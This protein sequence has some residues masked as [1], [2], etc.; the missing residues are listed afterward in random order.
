MD[1]VTGLRKVKNQRQQTIDRHGSGRLNAHSALA[2]VED[3]AK[4][5][6][7]VSGASAQAG[8]GWAVDPVTYCTPPV[9]PKNG[10]FRIN[11]RRPR[12][13]ATHRRIGSILTY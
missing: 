13:G 8:V 9:L 7:C 1:S 12:P 6:D 5:E 4:L 10:S 3:L 2:D 11:V